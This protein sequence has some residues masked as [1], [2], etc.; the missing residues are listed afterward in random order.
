MGPSAGTSEIPSGRPAITPLNPKRRLIYTDLR[1]TYGLRGRSHQAHQLGAG[2]GT[3]QIPAEKRPRLFEQ[4]RDPSADDR[5][6]P[7]SAADWAGAVRPHLT[8]PGPDNLNLQLRPCC[9]ALV[10]V[11]PITVLIAS[12]LQDTRTD[13]SNASIR[14][15]TG[16]E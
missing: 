11:R 8:H 5:G 1:R 7:A 15:L 2:V 12:L 9:R 6:Y 16:P 10:A 3:G 14:R 13:G 4:R